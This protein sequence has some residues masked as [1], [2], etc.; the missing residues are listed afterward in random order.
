MH[1]AGQTAGMYRVNSTESMHCVQDAEQQ[2]L[3]SRQIEADFV[4]TVELTF[5]CL[6]EL[7]IQSL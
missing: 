6:T 1:Y 4:F 7:M 3:I 2:P 5:L